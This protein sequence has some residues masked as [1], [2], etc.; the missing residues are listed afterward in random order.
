APTGQAAK[1]TPSLR[2][3][4]PNWLVS[5]HRRETFADRRKRSPYAVRRELLQSRRRR[6]GSARTRVEVSLEPGCRELHVAAVGGFVARKK[7]EA[8][9]Q[10]AQFQVLAQEKCLRRA[11]QRRGG[12]FHV[13][14]PDELLELAKKIRDQP[15][16]YPV[17]L[18]LGGGRRL[19]ASFLHERQG[20]HTRDQLIQLRGKSR[21]IQAGRGFK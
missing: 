17:G 10:Q 9:V 21:N 15:F 20:I 14:D 12:A 4:L 7:R 11:E 3:L 6:R 13:L 16:P 1:A 5:A 2:R 18:T 8:R 19:R